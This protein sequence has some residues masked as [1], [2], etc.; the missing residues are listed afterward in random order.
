MHAGDILL[1]LKYCLVTIYGYKQCCLTFRFDGELEGNA[2]P[3]MAHRV[4]KAAKT[5]A[6]IKT[7]YIM[8][9]QFEKAK[10]FILKKK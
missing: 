6:Q 7:N 10:Y 5:E 3:N 9:F 1:N 4:K 8:K 2:L